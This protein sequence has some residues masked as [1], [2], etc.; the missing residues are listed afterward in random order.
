MPVDNIVG[1]LQFLEESIRAGDPIECLKLAEAV[2]KLR[3]DPSWTQFGEFSK[4][5]QSISDRFH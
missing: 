1:W 4:I 3:I 5:G 2:E